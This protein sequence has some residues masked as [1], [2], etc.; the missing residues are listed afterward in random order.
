MAG[1]GNVSTTGNGTVQKLSPFQQLLRRMADMAEL[2][3]STERQSNTDD[4]ISAILTA[5]TEADMWT[6]D[7][8]DGWN[9]GKLSGS[10][11]QIQWFEVRKG[12]I[13]P[14]IKSAFIYDGYQFYLLVHCFRLTEAQADKSMKLPEIGREF[15]FNTSAPRIVGKL[16]WM[17]SEGWFDNGAPPVQVHIEGTKLTG[18]RTVEKLKPVKGGPITVQVIAENAD[19]EPAF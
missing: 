1:K 14:E 7:D 18:G 4:E 10:D 5:E 16:F 3:N 6:S 8:F 11:L 13:D 12:A 2:D 9:A 15:I 17:L 19:T